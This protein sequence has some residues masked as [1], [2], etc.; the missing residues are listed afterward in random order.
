MRRCVRYVRV[1][2][3]LLTIT[4]NIL[5]TI[6]MSALWQ[7][8]PG[9][10]VTGS[11]VPPSLQ[12]RQ[13]PHVFLGEISPSVHGGDLVAAQA[14]GRLYTNLMTNWMYSAAIQLS[15]N[16]SE[17]T[18]S[19]DGWSFVPVD[20]DS[21]PHDSNAETGATAG[22]AEAAETNV[23]LKTPAIR[24]RLECSP[25]PSLDNQTLWLT[26]HNVGNTS[27]WN[28]S[29]IPNGITEGYE[30]GC[31][32]QVDYEDAFRQLVLF[33]NTT[34]PGPCKNTKYTTFFA[35][36]RHIAC[37]VNNATADVVGPAS[38]GYWSPNFDDDYRFPQISTEWPFNLTVKWIHGTPFD[39]AYQY[40]NYNA[41]QSYPY[42][43]LLWT[44][45]PE[46]AA[47]NCMPVMETANASVS[48]S[49]P[50]GRV[51]AYKILDTPQPDAY[52]WLDV[53][54][55]RN[56]SSANVDNQGLQPQNMTMSHNVLFMLALLGAADL[57]KLA[58]P[59]IVEHELGPETLTDRTFN[60]RETGLNV[61]YMSYS[62]LSQVGGDQ[63]A[64]LDPQTLRRIANTVFS[65]YF[66]HFV[67]SNVTLA[68]GGWAYSKIG[69]A[70][71]R[72]LPPPVSYN[73][74]GIGESHAPNASVYY[75]PDAVQLTAHRRVE[76]LHMSVAAAWICLAI[77]VCLIAV[78]ILAATMR[79]QLT[80]GLR[81]EISCMADVAVLVAGSRALL[82]LIQAR[83]LEVVWR[84][85]T[86]RT[87]LGWFRGEDGRPRW[88]IELVDGEGADGYGVEW[89]NEEDVRDLDLN[90]K[91]AGQ[92]VTVGA[93]VPS[94]GVS[95]TPTSQTGGRED[96]RGASQAAGG[97]PPS[98]DTGLTPVS[99]ISMPVS[100]EEGAR[101]QEGLTQRRH[102]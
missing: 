67:S 73:Y 79:R 39:S 102:L 69:E 63:R 35:N 10:L 12:L 50:S 68:D 14:L 27:A 100:A 7:R 36:Q 25:I 28:A 21:I 57:T 2:K 84:D 33:P 70:L 59:D 56:F 72:D 1:S 31:D 89:L 99:P 64:L 82:G 61:D 8:E 15:L 6:A 86:L 16:G 11:S 9:Y 23:T 18:W 46:I 92:N 32:G 49:H 38:V 20:L 53:L 44:Q 81:R 26:K 24:G 41:S 85:E 101:H 60:F 74:N 37:C 45:V 5:V 19:H 88:G 96:G 76:M 62:M 54:V 48:L 3:S 34:L 75:G 42:P 30:L 71:P 95:V 52:G 93:S 80:G 78:L 98:V 58:G 83:G 55:D 22:S 40:T 94:S 90:E 47:L 17:P 65:T 13:I 43:N 97:S 91:P 51:H 4:D 66:Q 77:L 87:R 29:S